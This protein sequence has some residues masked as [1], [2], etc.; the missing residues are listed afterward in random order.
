VEAAAEAADQSLVPALLN[1]A[2][3][4]KLDTDLLQTAINNCRTG[5]KNG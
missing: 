1:L 2:P 3:R 5:R 4:W